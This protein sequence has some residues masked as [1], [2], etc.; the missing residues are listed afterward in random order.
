[1]QKKKCWQKLLENV[2][3]CDPFCNYNV[4]IFSFHQTAV[5][6]LCVHLIALC[7]QSAD[8][9]LYTT[10]C[11]FQ[12]KARVCVCVHLQAGQRRSAPSPAPRWIRW[13]GMFPMRVLKQNVWHQVGHNDILHFWKVLLHSGANR[14]NHSKS[15]SWT[16]ASFLLFRSDRCPEF[17]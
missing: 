11:Y 16:L 3:I 4:L 1:M 15:H 9:G 2:N 5:W 12:N 13:A 7:S 10:H 14:L 17:L 6:A 8:G